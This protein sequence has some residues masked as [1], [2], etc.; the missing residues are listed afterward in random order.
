VRLLLRRT[1]GLIGLGCTLLLIAASLAVADMRPIDE[2]PIDSA[3]TSMARDFFFM[4]I[5]LGS[6]RTRPYLTSAAGFRFVLTK[7]GRGISR[8]RDQVS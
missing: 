2:T 4:T 7:K 8:V 3:A 1:T 5:S 6:G